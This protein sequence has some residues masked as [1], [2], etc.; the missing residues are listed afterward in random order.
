[1]AH[2]FRLLSLYTTLFSV[3]H[4]LYLS[5]CLCAFSFIS[6]SFFSIL[7]DY[8]VQYMFLHL[9]MRR[10]VGGSIA[11]CPHTHQGAGNTPPPTLPH[12]EGILYAIGSIGFGMGGFLRG[13]GYVILSYPPLGGT[14]KKA[15]W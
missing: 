9:R 5:L 4:P 13:E 12:L 11:C 8:I 7:A 6:V 1:M 3:I 15:R 14:Q 10:G 2:A